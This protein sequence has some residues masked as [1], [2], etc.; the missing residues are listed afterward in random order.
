MQTFICWEWEREEEHSQLGEF[1]S[2]ISQEKVSALGAEA[3]ACLMV[4]GKWIGC[5]WPSGPL[6]YDHP[7]ICPVPRKDQSMPH[8]TVTPEVDAA[9]G[10]C[11]DH[12]VPAKGASD[13]SSCLPITPTSYLCAIQSKSLWK[14]LSRLLYVTGKIQII[15]ILQRICLGDHSEGIKLQ[16]KMS[17][18]SLCTRTH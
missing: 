7:G 11:Q 12:W 10:L 15:W 14:Y 3:G 1:P 16:L 17:L 9:L 2:S 6:S 13:G 5:L 8:P 18:R 4:R